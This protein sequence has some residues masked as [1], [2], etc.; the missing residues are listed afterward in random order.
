[1]RWANNFCTHSDG[2][3]HFV[4]GKVALFFVFA[5]PKTVFVVFARKLTTRSLR[6]ATFAQTAGLGLA[7]NARLWALRIWWEK[8]F[9][10]ADAV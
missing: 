3:D 10:F 9:S 5:T 2:R 7:S 6:R 1:L 4:A 8:E